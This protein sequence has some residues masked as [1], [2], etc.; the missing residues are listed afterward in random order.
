MTKERTRLSQGKVTVVG[1]QSL[2]DNYLQFIFREHG[3]NL[4]VRERLACRLWGSYRKMEN[5]SYMRF[6]GKWK[7]DIFTSPEN[8]KTY[9]I[10]LFYGK[11]L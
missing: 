10:S 3:L 7:F 5:I 8:D 9:S 2:L 11:N 1:K 4:E 6:V